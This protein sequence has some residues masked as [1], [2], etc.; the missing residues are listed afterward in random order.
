MAPRRS[1]SIS[2]EP[3]ALVVALTLSGAGAALLLI[4]VL[5]TA[6][7]VAGLIAIVLGT[8]LSAPYAEHRG[9]TISGWWNMLAAG[10]LLALAGAPL[11]LAVESLGGL[12][13][14]L[15]G[16]LVAIAVGLGFPAR[17]T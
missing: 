8:V 16:V 13:T 12:F 9:A 5:E 15:G 4:G 14:V 2:R 7:D 3:A 10:G 17:D 6:G 1:S 11:T